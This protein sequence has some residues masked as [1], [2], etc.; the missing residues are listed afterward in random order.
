VSD[1][2]IL[3]TL[4]VIEHGMSRLKIIALPIMNPGSRRGCVVS[5]T[6]WP[7]YSMKW[8]PVLIVQ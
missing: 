4:L 2:T 3:Y 7:L 6:P 5:D 1:C 8:N